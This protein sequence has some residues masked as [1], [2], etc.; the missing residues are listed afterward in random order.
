[1]SISIGS[2]SQVTKMNFAHYVFRRNDL[3]LRK[4]AYMNKNSFYIYLA[5][6]FFKIQS[7]SKASLKVINDLINDFGF[8]E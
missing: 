3:L 8:Q 5:S 2:R 7:V 4:M 6:D 1:M